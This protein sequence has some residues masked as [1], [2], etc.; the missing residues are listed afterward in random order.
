MRIA[1][2]IEKHKELKAKISSND[3]YSLIHIS[4]ELVLPQK[5]LSVAFHLLYV[6]KDELGIEPDDIILF[7]AIVNLSTKISETS[8]PLEIIFKTVCNCFRI[9]VPDS[10]KSN[11]YDSIAKTEIDIC[12]IIDFNFEMSELYTKLEMACKKHK[13]DQSFSK[14]AWIF[15]NDI[16][17]TPLS[18]FFTTNEIITAALF[19]SYTLSYSS[20]S[21]EIISN[22]QLF[23]MFLDVCSSEC[24][25]FLAIEHIADEII[26]LYHFYKSIKWPIN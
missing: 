11:Y 25:T 19:L 17:S 9:D 6:S 7:T 15:L 8:R 14:R 20:K 3:K 12:I 24:K 10:I 1:E 5:T 21:K 22:K 18:A 13:F 23:S 4:K 16:M 26:T 2:S